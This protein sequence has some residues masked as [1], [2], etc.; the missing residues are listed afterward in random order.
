MIRFQR[1]WR[2]YSK[3][4]LATFRDEVEKDLIERGVAVKV[5][6]PSAPKKDEGDVAKSV[7]KN[8]NKDPGKPQDKQTTVGPQKR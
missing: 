4:E 8:D 3:D 6:P 2:A 1:S 7:D 5:I